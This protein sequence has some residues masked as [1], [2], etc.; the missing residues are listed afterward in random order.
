VLHPLVKTELEQFLEKVADN[1]GVVSRAQVKLIWQVITQ[2]ALDHLARERK[3]LDLG[4]CVLHPC[5]Y[6]GSWKAQLMQATPSLMQGLKGQPK[7]LHDAIFGLAGVNDQMR[8][9]CM[10]AFDVRHRAIYWG[11]EVEPKKEWH[12][13]SMTHENAKVLHLGPSGYFKY[14][15]KAITRL[16][17]RL[18]SLYLSWAKA[19]SKPM[20]A[21]GKTSQGR[22]PY[23]TPRI[24]R[25]RAT[26][27]TPTYFPEPAVD[28]SDPS[29]LAEQTNADAISRSAEGL[30]QMPHLLARDNDVREA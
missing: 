22:P 26:P 1:S 19:L 5:P 30:R 10:L 2:E 12:R 20:A 15:A 27:D 16:R 9:T 18:L 25:G 7:K 13:V 21:P 28:Y 29:L 24:P 8:N 11:L 6:R 14:V 23:L 4:F 3:S 17:P